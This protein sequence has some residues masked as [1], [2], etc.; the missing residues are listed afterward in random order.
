[1]A[2][3]SVP[4]T[5]KGLTGTRIGN[6]YKGDFRFLRP[7]G[8]PCPMCGVK[9]VFGILPGSIWLL[10]LALVTSSLSRVF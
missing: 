9:G 10:E 3:V 5:D 8:T 1:M 4:K 2:W 6:P 7:G